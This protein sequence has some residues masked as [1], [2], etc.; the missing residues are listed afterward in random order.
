MSR[1]RDFAEKRS[2]LAQSDVTPFLAPPWCSNLENSTAW[3]GGCR[4]SSFFRLVYCLCGRDIE[5]QLAQFLQGDRFDFGHLS[6]EQL[7]KVDALQTKVVRYENSYSARLAE[8]QNDMLDQPLAAF[9][10]T[11]VPTVPN[12][13]DPDSCDSTGMDANN[14]GISTHIPYF[15]IM[16][17][18][19]R[20]ISRPLTS[21][22]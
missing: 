17:E 3:V 12:S 4:P 22:V 20:Y 1:F 10:E 8:L 18:L 19:T 2:R 6:A 21:L 9:V 13:E 11:A 16:L 15:K 14:V 7:Q 5:K